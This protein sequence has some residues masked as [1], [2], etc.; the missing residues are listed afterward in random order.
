MIRRPASHL[1]PAKITSLSINGNQAHF[2]GT[3]KLSRKSTV[4]FTVDVIDNGTPG[5]FDS[6]SIQ[7]SNGYSAGGTL[8]SGDI[9]I[10]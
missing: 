6:F 7:V 10:R 5:T 8:S 2:T 9:S 1:G 4:S 3:V